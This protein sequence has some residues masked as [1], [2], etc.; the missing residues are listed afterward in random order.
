MTRQKAARTRL[1]PGED[2]VDR[3]ADSLPARGPYQADISVKTWEGKLRRF[4][5]RATTKGEFRAKARDKAREALNSGPTGWTKAHKIEDFIDDVSA[6]T[7]RAARVRPNTLKRYELALSQV[8]CE[9]KGLSTGEAVRFR[10]LE[11]ALKSIATQHGAESAR[12]ARTVTSKYIIDQ[13]IR[14]EVIDHNPLRGVSIDPGVVRKGSK[15]AHGVALTN[16]QYD[17][18]L[19]HLIERDTSGPMPPGTDKRQTSINKHDL[20]V[21]LTILQAA[22]GL[23]ISEVLALTR[24]NV[25]ETRD[26][27][28]VT[29]SAD[30]SKT[31]R[32]RTVPL[33]DE[34]AERYWRE[35]LKNIEPGAPIIPAPG[36]K[37]S[38][39]RTDNAV[40][41]TAALYKDLGTVLE[42]ETISAMRSHGWRTVLNNRAIARG[43][44]AEVRA[45][46]FG[47]T[48]DVNAS[49]Y[50]DLVDVESMAEALRSRDKRMSL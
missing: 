17:A 44:A 8:R 20:T 28:A 46:F 21:A 45:A 4:K 6:P 16:S 9:L 33:L 25:T 27:L 30:V 15:P 2:S 7:I 13:L 39:W 10:T 3:V 5:I 35:R 43:V 18:V 49:S 1:A 11:R 48:Q 31:H 38:H 41:A 29:V 22:T 34:R 40:K 12:Q 24:D 37:R 23:R 32:A 42:D 47:H 36:D 50:T 26:A 14:E 19:N